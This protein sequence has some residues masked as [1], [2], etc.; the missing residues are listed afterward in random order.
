MPLGALEPPRHGRRR[1]TARRLPKTKMAA[2]SSVTAM[3]PMSSFWARR[4]F[5]RISG[6]LMLTVSPPTTASM[7][8]TTGGGRN[9]PERGGTGST[10]SRAWWRTMQAAG[11]AVLSTLRQTGTLKSRASASSS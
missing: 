3:S 5:L 8:A 4:R 11:V 9:E 10:E 1:V 7:R 2:C 6:G